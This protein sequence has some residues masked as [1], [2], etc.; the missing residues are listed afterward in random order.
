MLLNMKLQGR[1]DLRDAGA[2]LY[3]LN[4]HAMQLGTGC[5]VG[6]W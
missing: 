1:P 2:V 5:Y 3:K 6:S 4:N